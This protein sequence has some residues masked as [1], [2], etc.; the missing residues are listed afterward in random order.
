MLTII[1]LC[2]IA[3]NLQ[4][5]KSTI[6][7]KHNKVKLNKK[8]WLHILIYY[9]VLQFNNFHFYQQC[10]WAREALI[11]SQSSQFFSTMAGLLFILTAC[12]GPTDTLWVKRSRYA[13]FFTWSSWK[14][15]LRAV[16]IVL[17]SNFITCVI[18]RFISNNRFILLIIFHIFLQAW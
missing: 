18:L 4:F 6:A 14:S 2:R 7:V 16:F 15:L 17:S 1:W 3:I 9:L 8:V 13:Y 11:N 10:H 12:P 5:V